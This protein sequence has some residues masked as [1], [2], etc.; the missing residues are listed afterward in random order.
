M[1]LVAGTLA[2]HGLKE[3]AIVNLSSIVGKTGNL[4]QCN[5]AASKAAVNGLTKT[6]ARELAKW[7]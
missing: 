7:V 2:E 5:Y 4:G 3:G 1:Q 6:A